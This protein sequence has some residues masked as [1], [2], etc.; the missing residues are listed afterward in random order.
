ML[1]SSCSV[2]NGFFPFVYIHRAPDAI[3]SET[4]FFVVVF[5]LCTKA[6]SRS[7]PQVCYDIIRHTQQVPG[8]SLLWDHQAHTVGPRLKFAMISSG[9]H[10]RS[11]AQVCYELETI[12]RTQQIPGSRLLWVHQAHTADPRLK[13]TMSSSGIHRRSQAQVYYESIRHTQ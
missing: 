11:Q 8:S 10:S 9:T 7:Q 4:C 3:R 6:Q 5:F 13:I 2:Y 12:R 1:N